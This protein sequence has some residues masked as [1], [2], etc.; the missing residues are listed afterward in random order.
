MRLFDPLGELVGRQRRIDP[1]DARIAGFPKTLDGPLLDAFEQQN[2]DFV[3][4]ERIVS[5]SHEVDFVVGHLIIVEMRGPVFN[6]SQPDRSRAHRSFR[7]YAPRGPGSRGDHE[8][9]S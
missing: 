3:L 9:I 7:R 4:G 2:P 6:H 8:R 1:F 5:L